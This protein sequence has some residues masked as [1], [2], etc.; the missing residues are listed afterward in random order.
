MLVLF[1]GLFRIREK[2]GIEF[3]EYEYKDAFVVSWK[4]VGV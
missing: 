1:V 4:I 3:K 2:F